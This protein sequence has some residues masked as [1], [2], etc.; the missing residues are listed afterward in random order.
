ML[1]LVLPKLN[2][3]IH[4]LHSYNIKT[5]HRLPA[6]IRSLAKSLPSFSVVNTSLETV[7]SSRPQQCA[8]HFDCSRPF[9]SPFRCSWRFS[10]TQDKATTRQLGILCGWSGRLE[11]ST[12][13]HWFSTYII[14]FQLTCTLH[15][16][17]HFSCS[18]FTD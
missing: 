1:P 13:G 14:N 18:Y 7:K 6:Y 2:L 3:S 8:S 11:Q 16:T 9:C 12:T 5:T 4:P 17:H 10:R 15:K